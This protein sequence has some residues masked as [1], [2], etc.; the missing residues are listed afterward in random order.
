MWDVH[1]VHD[2]EIGYCQG[3][4]TVAAILIM[5]MREEVSR[6]SNFENDF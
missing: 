6:F 3:M 1:T 2:P 5:F 4:G